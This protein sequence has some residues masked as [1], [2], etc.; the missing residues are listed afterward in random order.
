MKVV[1]L[2]EGGQEIGFGHITRC[3]AL[4]QAFDK[5]GA[6]TEFIV[7]GDS[8]TKELL[9]DNKHRTFNWLK[10]RN[11]LFELA[12]YANLV[13]IDSYLAAKSIYDSISEITNGQMAVIDDYRRLEYPRGIVINPSI[14]GDELNYPLK[15]ELVYLLG[16]NYIILRNEFRKIPQKKINK[17]V[18]NILI[19][20][21]GVNCYD[22]VHKIIDDCKASFGFNFYTIDPEKKKLKAKEMLDLMLETDIC[23]SGGGQTT[24]ELAR[25][26][27]PTIGICF[28]EN[29]KLNLEGWQ[30][31][32]F[33]D[34]VGECIDN[35]ISTKIAEAINNL[36]PRRERVMRSEI[37]RRNVDGKG[38]ERIGKTLSKVQ[39]HGLS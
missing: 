21:G 1:I 22:L 16:K 20:F 37:G 33:I 36:I 39:A 6:A 38:A 30:K 8:K 24:Y 31:K 18:K 15:E 23:I 28:A 14:Y 7:N 25:V 11:K 17:E 35:D 10:E 13:I 3:I 4:C 29:Q 27:I 32:G 26:G 12:S 2:T 34:Y 9:K 19:T 5:E